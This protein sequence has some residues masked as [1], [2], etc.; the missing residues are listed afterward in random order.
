MDNELKDIADR[1]HGYSNGWQ[2]YAAEKQ[3][4]GSWSLIIQPIEKKI[5]AEP[6]ATDDQTD[7]A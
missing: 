2:I 3:P 6:E 4:D 7:K 5:D 1:L